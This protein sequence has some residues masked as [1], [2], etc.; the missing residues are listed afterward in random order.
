MCAATLL[1][2]RRAGMKLSWHWGP[3]SFLVVAGRTS[4]PHSAPVSS[5]CRQ[6][7]PSDSRWRAASLCTSGTAQPG[8]LQADLGGPWLQHEM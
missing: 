1:G 2:P 7:T 6:R 4:S 5:L 3:H 8:P